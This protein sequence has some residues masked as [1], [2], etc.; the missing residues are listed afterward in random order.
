MTKDFS[1]LPEKPDKTFS[2]LSFDFL[3]SP[4][5]KVPTEV[6]QAVID[7]WAPVKP[8]EV[9]NSYWYFA[10]ERQCIFF[11]KLRRCSP[12]WT[13]DQILTRYKFTNAYRASDRVSQYLIK[14][15]I[16]LI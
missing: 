10:A 4:L 11:K 7:D 8:T 9:F 5:V 13:E 14:N 1:S 6:S 15:V 12:P 3:Q 2:Q 16:Y